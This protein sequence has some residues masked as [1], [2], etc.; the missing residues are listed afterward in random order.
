M[1]G[2]MPNSDIEA[3]TSDDSLGD[4]FEEIESAVQETERG[5]WFLREFARRQ[6]AVETAEILT[7]LERLTR[8]MAAYESQISRSPRQSVSNEEPPT[9]TLAAV[10]TETPRSPCRP[11][12]D[13]SERLAALREIDA[14]EIEEKVRL[15]A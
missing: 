8:R 2:M 1:D 4:N 11:R 14:L 3:S 15:F 12:G 5:R 13:L 10:E 7:A 9:E 6:R